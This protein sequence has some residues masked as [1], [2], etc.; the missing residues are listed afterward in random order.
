MIDLYKRIWD[1][2]WRAQIPLIFLS[3]AIAALA[4]FPLQ[5]QK[6]IIDGLA[7]SISK[8]QLLSLSAQYLFVAVLASGLKF[9]LQYK[10]STL[11]ESIIRRIRVQICENR[12]NQGSKKTV[13]D[14]ALVTMVT[15]EAE[16]IGSFAGVAITSPLV[17]I[18]TLFSVVGFVVATQPNLGM[19]MVAVILPQA[20]VVALTQKKINAK[21]KERV[22]TLRHTTNRIIEEDLKKIQKEILEDFDRIYN[23]R[24]KIFMFKLS[25]K[26]VL[27]VITGIGTIGILTL[28]GL[29]VLEGKTSIGIVVAALSGLTRVT[30]PWRELIS[31]Y[32][33]LS[34]TRIK[35]DLLV[36][37][38]PNYN[39]N[40]A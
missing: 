11:S 27:N 17:Q 31:F 20:L 32:R 8:Q 39:K 2:S 1:V 40:N 14:G 9:A 33:S 21:I 22:Q 5:F 30:E 10:S 28:G 16:E 38:L 7:G 37:S 13:G 29:M 23:L 4:A 35:F 6:E 3:L 34:A 12:K 25:T 36:S 18:A 15:S 24:R 26:F 19:F